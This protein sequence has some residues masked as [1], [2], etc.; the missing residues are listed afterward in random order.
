MKHTLANAL[1]V[2]LDFKSGKEGT[3]E[4]SR[5]CVNV[6]AVSD[7]ANKSGDQFAA[8][9]Y[10]CKKYT[11]I[12]NYQSRSQGHYGHIV[13]KTKKS[14]SWRGLGNRGE[15]MDK[16]HSPGDSVIGHIIIC[17]NRIKDLRP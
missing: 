9:N 2:A 8:G 14:P 7:E 10:Y 3:K 13:K 6:L 5:R 12:H 4:G 16:R 1:L 17:S 11:S 15:E